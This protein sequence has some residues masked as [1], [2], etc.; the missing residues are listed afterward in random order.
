MEVIKKIVKILGISFL[1]FYL[2]YLIFI[3]LAFVFKTEGTD[4]IDFPGA[5]TLLALSSIIYGFFAVL[6][7]YISSLIDKRVF[8]KG[9][10]FGFSFYWFVTISI[11]T[12][13]ENK[14]VWFLNSIWYF[15]GFI[16]IPLVVVIVLMNIKKWIKKK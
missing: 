2:P 11:F 4:L 7:L 15:W 9:F 13:L 6:V 10:V 12:G 1:G 8:N 5:A 14:S 3:I 16:L